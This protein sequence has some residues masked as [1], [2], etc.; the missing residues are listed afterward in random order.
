MRYFYSLLLV[1]FIS[2]TSCGQ[3][4]SLPELI[5]MSKMNV[6]D[7]DTFVSAKGYVFIGK[8]DD[9]KKKGVNYAFDY[10]SSNGVANKFIT[11]Y[12]YYQGYKTLLNY[13]T[14]SKTEYVNIKKQIK[15]LGFNLVESGP[16]TN[17]NGETSNHLMYQKGKAEISIFTAFNRYEINYSVTY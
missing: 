5:K 8:E 15:A 3:T 1:I 13:Q 7:F 10:H 17:K 6:D 14:L 12:S 9:S 16:F 11:L 2:F 4:F